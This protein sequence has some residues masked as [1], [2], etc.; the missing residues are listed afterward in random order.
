MEKSVKKK[1]CGYFVGFV[2]FCFSNIS[3]DMLCGMG[4]SKVKFTGSIIFLWTIRRACGVVEI[5]TNVQEQSIAK[6]QKCLVARTDF[7]GT[8]AIDGSNTMF[9]QH[10]L[11]GSAKLLR[12]RML[13]EVRSCIQLTYDIFSVARTSNTSNSLGT[14][15]GPSN[16]RHTVWLVYQRK[17]LCVFYWSDKVQ[18]KIC[19]KCTG[20]L[21]LFRINLHLSYVHRF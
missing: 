13:S 10:F 9:L 21:P 17:K 5:Y 8:P 3:K 1:V 19:F 4:L 2:G 14:K 12:Y 6:V 15:H 7:A 11:T 16:L 20:S 18:C